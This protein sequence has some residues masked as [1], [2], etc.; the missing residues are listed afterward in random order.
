MSTPVAPQVRPYVSPGRDDVSAASVVKALGSW[1]PAFLGRAIDPVAQ[2]FVT[3]TETRRGWFRPRPTAAGAGAAGLGRRGACQR[4]QGSTNARETR[5]C[6]PWA[7]IGSH[8]RCC[9]RCR[10]AQLHASGARGADSFIAPRGFTQNQR[11]RWHPSCHCLGCL[12]PRGRRRH[13]LPVCLDPPLA[14]HP[15]R[16]GLDPRQPPPARCRRTH[17]QRDHHPAARSGP[18]LARWFRRG[19]AEVARAAESA[20][21][22]WGACGKGKWISGHSEP[23]VSRQTSKP[24]RVPR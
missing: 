22:S 12:C 19:S 2:R 3:E 8:L 6:S 13:P 15:R 14:D 11:G 17:R 21:V 16:T 20:G 9:C 10:K 24:S 5:I 4:S 7:D 1:G 23:M 18:G